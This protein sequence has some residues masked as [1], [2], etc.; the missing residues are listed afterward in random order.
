ML[1]IRRFEERV[2]ELVNANEIAGVTH[3]Y[4]GQEAVAAGVCAALRP[5][6][7]ITSTHRGH[8]HLIAKGADVRRMMAELL[9]RVDGL[10]RAPRRL[11]AHRRPRRSG[12]TAPTGSSPR[13]RRSPPAR[14]GASR[15]DGSGRDRRHVLRR[16]RRQPGR[17]ARDDEPGRALEA[18]GGLRLREQR[19]R[20]D[21]GRRSARPP[22]RS[23]SAPPRTAWPPSGSTAWTSRRCS[24]RPRRAVARA[25][26][27]RRPDVPRVPDLPLLRPPHRRADDE[28]RLPQ[29]RGDRGAGACATRS[30]SRARALGEAERERIA[31]GGR[32]A[33]RRRAS[34]SPARAR[35]PTRR[36]RSSTCTRPASRPREGRRRDDAGPVPAGARQGAPR[37]DGRRPERLRASAR[38]SA[39]RC[40]A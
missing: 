20:R 12:S 37:R 38:T 26:R 39:R 3:E 14:R 23:S 7:V 6:D 29:R 36:T 11:D 1:L 27:G 28:A 21:A 16:R 24:R 10:N 8:G 5:D 30:P 13:A 35:G 22:A 31:R 4:V 25:A 32:G 19:L 2:V 34:R 17:A 18:A 33:A 40:A 9:G 15:V